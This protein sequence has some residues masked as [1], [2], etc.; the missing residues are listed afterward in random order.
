M[1]ARAGCSKNMQ[2]RLRKSL[3]PT[4]RSESMASLEISQPAAPAVALPEQVRKLTVRPYLPTDAPRWD[5]FVYAQAEGSPFH[6]T[7]WQ[8]A[9]PGTF[10]YEP[11]HP[12]VERGADS[13]G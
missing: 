1:P 4:R 12:L 8:G 9:I 7:A 5:R 3:E 11:C 6:S 2:H 10:G 13:T